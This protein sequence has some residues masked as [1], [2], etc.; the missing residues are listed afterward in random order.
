MGQCGDQDWG[1][2]GGLARKRTGVLGFEPRAKSQFPHLSDGGNNTN[3]TGWFRKMKPK[4][5]VQKIDK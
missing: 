4:Q 1:P 3:F 5:L 2:L